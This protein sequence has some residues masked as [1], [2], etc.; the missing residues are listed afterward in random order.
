MLIL[1]VPVVTIA[2]LALGIVGAAVSALTPWLRRE[3][4]PSSPTT[5]GVIEGE[6]TVVAEHEPGHTKRPFG[7]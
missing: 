3:T 7:R 6:Y 4:A 2:L 1:V 5:P